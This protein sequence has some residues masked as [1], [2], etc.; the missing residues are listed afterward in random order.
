MDE[1]P[2]QIKELREMPEKSRPVLL[3]VICLFAFVFYGIISLF[4][5]ISVFYSGWITD[6]VNKYAPQNIHSKAYILMLVL[7]GFVFHASS[8]MGVIK[9]WKMKKAGYYWFSLSSLTIALFQLFNHRI[10]ASS[11]AV[12]IGLIVLFGLFY[13]KYQ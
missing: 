8:L 3:T 11:T 7:G 13:R 12:Y 4:L 2:S 5:L 10:P 1:Q 6:V 9:I